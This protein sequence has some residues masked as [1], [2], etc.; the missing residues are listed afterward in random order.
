MQNKKQTSDTDFKSTYDGSIFSNARTV[1]DSINILTSSENNIKLSE[2]I[3]VLELIE[4]IGLSKT[5]YY[6]A[7]IPEK[8]RDKLLES[9]ELLS[10]NTDLNSKRIKPYKVEDNK[11]VILSKK[12]FEN[13]IDSIIELTQDITLLKST[14]LA[15]SGGFNEYQ[16]ATFDSILE[17]RLNI[18]NSELIDEFVNDIQNRNNVTGRRF[19]LNLCRN[20]YEE[21]FKTYYNYVKGLTNDLKSSFYSKS[22]NTFRSHLLNIYAED[23]QSAYQPTDYSKW[24]VSELYAKQAWRKVSSSI[25]KN[26]NV[27]NLINQSKTENGF[28]GNPTIPPFAISVLY[29]SSNVK[30][31][32]DLINFAVSESKRRSFLSYRKKMWEASFDEDKYRSF[33]NLVEEAEEDFQRFFDKSQNEKRS[34]KLIFGIDLPKIQLSD[35]LA[36]LGG[37][38]LAMYLSAPLTLGIEMLAFKL[39]Q[40]I[41]NSTGKRGFLSFYR[42][43][44]T[45]LNGLNENVF[46]SKVER[47]FG[48]SLKME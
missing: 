18:Q 26:S 45:L 28:L 2:L 24:A 11:K 9:V 35:F 4:C 41:Y 38:V 3:Q 32:L 37:A 10:K 36:G 6:D 5:F 46:I 16:I 1:T 21:E 13:A 14:S 23:T 48:K 15:T 40:N 31:G 20:E 39:G 19:V 30:N 17:E 33:T 25:N 43:Q 12:A 8:Y 44:R 42:D 47:V 27:Q 29:N 7:S 34:S 22:I